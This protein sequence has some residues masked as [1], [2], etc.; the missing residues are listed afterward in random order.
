MNK[1]VSAAAVCAA[2][3][4]AGAPLAGGTAT[5]RP[6]RRADQQRAGAGRR[7]TA[8]GLPGGYKHLVVIYEENHSFDNL[9]GGWGTV[10]GQPST[11]RAD[12]TAAPHDPGR[13]GRHAVLLP[14]RRT[15]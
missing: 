11:G 12:A 6:R 4:V 5:A 9:Y 15:T 10:D 8:P 7:G 13:P 3:V 14:A 1:V 2:V